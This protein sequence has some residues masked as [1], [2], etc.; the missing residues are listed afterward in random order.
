MWTP[1]PGIVKQGI[2]KFSAEKQDSRGESN[3]KLETRTLGIS[4]YDNFTKFKFECCAKKPYKKLR[5]KI[6]SFSSLIILNL[7]QA[8]QKSSISNFHEV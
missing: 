3:A 5:L 8:Q 7:F 4:K 6:I 2:E 1:R